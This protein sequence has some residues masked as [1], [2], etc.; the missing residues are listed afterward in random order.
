[1]RCLTRPA[2]AGSPADVLPE[3]STPR[4]PSDDAALQVANLSVDVTVS[5]VIITW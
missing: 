2:E 5:L 3:E 1:M 4:S